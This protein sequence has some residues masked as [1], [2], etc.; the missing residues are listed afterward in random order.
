MSVSETAPEVASPSVWMPRRVLSDAR[1]ARLAGRGDQRAFEAIFERYHQELYRYCRGILADPDEAQDAL[2][3]TMASALRSLPGDERQIVLRPWLYRV[4]HN[5]AVSILRQRVGGLGAERLPDLTAAGA[6]SEAEARE[7][8]RDLVADLDHLPERQRGALVMREL[9]GLSYDEIGT[10]LSASPAAARQAVYEAR[11][12][13]RDLNRGREM[14][15]EAARRAL[16]DRDGRVLR[17]RR[18]R[19]H[20]RACEACSGFEAAISQRRA[21]L[22]ALCPPLPGLAA[23]GLLTTI[24]GG[25]GNGGVGPA[26]GALAGGTAGVAGGSTIAGPIAVKGASIAAAIV[27]GAGAAG[28]SGVV[29]VPLVGERDAPVTQGHAPAALPG[30]AQ[31]GNAS[32]TAGARDPGSAG[33]ASDRGRAEASSA[34][35]APGRHQSH[36]GDETGSAGHA[37]RASGAQGEVPASSPSAGLPATAN[38][39]PPAHSNAGGNSHGG[40]NASAGSKGKPA[41]PPGHANAASNAPSLPAHA[42]GKPG[43]PP[44]HSRTPLGQS[45]TPLSQSRSS[46][47]KSGSSHGRSASSPVRA[48]K[49]KDSA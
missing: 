47:G 10:A 45:K 27:V 19:A 5:E 30:A 44:G 25:T 33:N 46:S 28:M 8:L 21:D 1:L 20:L 29:K 2:Q 40:G 35:E 43:S 9:S 41:S 22:R 48:S 3:N 13:L 32:P 34:A 15:C 18:L 14:E 7:R 39:N 16:S 38:G 42:Q 36:G 24:L 49:A 4:A 23:S 26:T 12:A 6:D 37:A 11:V 31:H 17:S